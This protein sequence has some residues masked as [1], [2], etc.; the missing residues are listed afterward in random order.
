MDNFHKCFGKHMIKLLSLKNLWAMQ[1]MSMQLCNSMLHKK[2]WC[3]DIFFFI[4]AN[5]LFLWLTLAV[6]SAFIMI[7]RHC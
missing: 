2:N 4:L 5:L 6:V 1:K 7:I 3:K